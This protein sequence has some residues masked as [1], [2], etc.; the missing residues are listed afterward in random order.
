MDNTTD[1]NVATLPKPQKRKRTKP[2]DPFAVPV[3]PLRQ[4]NNPESFMQS[5]IHTIR[6]VTSVVRAS[7]TREQLRG[8][9]SEHAFKRVDG[10][11]T[12]P[13]VIAGKVCMV[14]RDSSG[15]FFIES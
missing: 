4:V 13:L 6:P 12:W 1:N 2:V 5:A 7:A 9:L 8:M 11:A 10:G 14:G 3:I 15:S